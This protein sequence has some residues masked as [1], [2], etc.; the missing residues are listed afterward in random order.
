MFGFPNMPYTDMNMS[1]P[2]MKDYNAFNQQLLNYSNYPTYFPADYTNNW[3]SQSATNGETHSKETSK[4]NSS[5]VLT[6]NQ[7]TNQT[8]NENQSTNNTTYY[9]KYNSNRKSYGRRQQ[10]A[11]KTEE[12]KPAPPVKPPVYNLMQNEQVYTNAFPALSTLS[13]D[14]EKSTVVRIDEIENN[15]NKENKENINVSTKSSNSCSSSSSSSAADKRWSDIVTGNR[16]FLQTNDFCENASK[17][18]TDLI[19]NLCLNT[20][21]EIEKQESKNDT[22][23]QRKTD[24]LK[25]DNKATQS[26]NQN[27]KRNKYNKN[28]NNN[29]YRLNAYQNQG[30]LQN[31]KLILLIIC[32]HFDYL[33]SESNF[34]SKKIS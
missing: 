7:S 9:K 5:R 3:S 32:T 6:S 19:D 16:N 15:E 17:L 1:Y 27:G 11:N 2:Y 30:K 8:T 26:T 13:I 28:Y 20:S 31:S 14:E 10:D 25:P 4:S 33:N 22:E 34:N 24:E 12:A 23:E 18:E 21:E 29:N